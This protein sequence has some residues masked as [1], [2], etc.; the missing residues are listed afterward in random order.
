LKVLEENKGKALM[1]ATISR[2]MLSQGHNHTMNP[3]LV[4]LD[5]LISQGKVVKVNKNQE[6]KRAY[7]GVPNV[8]AD[9]TKILIEILRDGSKREIECGKV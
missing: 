1:A 9:G 8:K 5:L 6:H 4:N 2:F 7:Y 3:I